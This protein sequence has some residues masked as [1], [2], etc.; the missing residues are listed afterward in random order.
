MITHSQYHAYWCPCN[1]NQQGIS[2]HNIDHIMRAMITIWQELKH[3]HN[4][5]PRTKKIQWVVK[6]FLLFSRKTLSLALTLCVL[7]AKY[8]VN[9][10]SNVPA[11]T[12]WFP[13]VNQQHHA[14]YSKQ[15]SGRSLSTWTMNFHHLHYFILGIRYETWLRIYAFSE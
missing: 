6:T 1:V 7:L 14:Q 10:V 9:Q 8:C 5:L 11:D 4:I 13:A 12:H 15:K 2:R 3:M